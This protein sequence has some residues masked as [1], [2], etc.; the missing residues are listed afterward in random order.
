MTTMRSS[1]DRLPN[2]WTTVFASLVLATGCAPKYEDLKAFLQAHENDV[3]A[4]D[5]RI[6]PPDI[7]SI[8]SPTAPEIDNAVQRI[9]SD[10]KISLKLLGEVKVS[11]LTPR[12]AAAKIEEL[13]ARYYVS[14]TV[15]VRVASYESKKVYAFGQV[16]G[17]GA[18]PFTGRNTVLDVLSDAQ[19]NFIAWNEQVKV[20]RPSAAP[21]ER[22]T[23]TVDVNKMMQT[24]DLTSNFLLQEGDIVYVPPTPL[25]QLGLWINQLLFPF[26]PLLNAYEEPYRFKNSTE[27][28]TEDW[29][30]QNQDQ[31]HD[32]RA[33]LLR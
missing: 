24:G 26:S 23:M 2:A 4:A 14:P 28:Y 7:I 27:Y 17:K 30:R 16:G 1:R 5:Y 10:G 18:R 25:G 29:D 33:L 32:R 13:L 8:H 20:I 6:E 3:A 22:H 31:H 9:R 21:G 19:P 11:G 15:I 12:E